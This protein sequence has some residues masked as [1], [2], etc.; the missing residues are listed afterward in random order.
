[1]PFFACWQRSTL[2]VRAR[3]LLALAGATDILL[4]YAVGELSDSADETTILNQSFALVRHRVI[5]LLMD[6]AIQVLVEVDA[7][8]EAE[9]EARA[10]LVAGGGRC[11]TARHRRTPAVPR[12][13]TWRHPTGAL[14][15]P[16]DPRPIPARSGLRPGVTTRMPSRGSRLG[17]RSS[18]AARWSI[19]DRGPCRR[20][21]M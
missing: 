21:G 18:A 17:R 13:G 4:A 1:M 19:A 11:T 3:S 6:H 2:F 14:R 16:P 8:Q 12:R 5:G 7:Q 15:T 9:E 10:D 20:S